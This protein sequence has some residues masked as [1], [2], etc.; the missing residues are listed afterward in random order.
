MMTPSRS[1]IQNQLRELAELQKALTDTLAS[2]PNH[3][4]EPE[5]NG[6]PTVITFTLSFRVNGATTGRMP[7][8]VYVAMVRRGLWS[9]SGMEAPAGEITWTDLCEWIT[10]KGGTIEPY[11][12]VANWKEGDAIPFQ[13]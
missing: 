7:T 5:D 11:W 2:M 3:P 6:E 10:S 12:Y 1:E 13:S 9:V 8:H 4:E